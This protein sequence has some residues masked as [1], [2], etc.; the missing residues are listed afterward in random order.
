MNLAFQLFP[1]TKFKLQECIIHVK[2]RNPVQVI[3]FLNQKL[4]FCVPI[5]TK[6]KITNIIQKTANT[7]QKGD[8]VAFTYKI[9]KFIKISNAG[10][11]AIAL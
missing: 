4:N 8:G 1:H 9:D 7:G 5:K 6:N 11:D 2:R 3:T 10:I